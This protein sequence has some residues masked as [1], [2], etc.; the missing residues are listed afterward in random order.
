MDRY[1]IAITADSGKEREVV[2]LVSKYRDGLAELSIVATMET[3][4]IIRRDTGLQVG[5]LKESSD[6]GYFHIAQ[7]VAHNDVKMVIC[8]FNP[9]SINLDY[10]GMRMMLQL[11][12]LHDIPMANNVATAEFIIERFLERQM[13]TR[14]RCPAGVLV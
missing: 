11:C 6:G 9:G 10:P 1:D 5:L 13:A 4:L 2:D 8:L 7:L 12:T 14:Y 3:A